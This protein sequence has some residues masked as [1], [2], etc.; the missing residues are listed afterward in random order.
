[1]QLRNPNHSPLT[2]LLKIAVD[3]IR[4]SGRADCLQL[5]DDLFVFFLLVSPSRGRCRLL[6]LA[7]GR[8]SSDRLTRLRLLS[9]RSALLGVRFAH[10]QRLRR[11]LLARGGSCGVSPIERFLLG[12]M[13]WGCSVRRGAIEDGGGALI[14]WT[15]TEAWWFRELGRYPS[16]GRRGSSVGLAC[17]RER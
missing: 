8:L 15:P 16:W 4:I 10:G 11:R 13:C 6:A 5:P 14:R 3:Q 12:R 9:R 1:M 17:Q 7:L 2:D